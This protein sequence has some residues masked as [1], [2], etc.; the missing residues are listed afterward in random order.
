MVSMSRMPSQRSLSISPSCS[1][2]AVGDR[3]VNIVSHNPLGSSPIRI[4]STISGALVSAP[5]CPDPIPGLT[6]ASVIYCCQG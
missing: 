2:H 4:A 1:S 6:N 5:P 3:F